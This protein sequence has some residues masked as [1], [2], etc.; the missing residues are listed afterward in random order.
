MSRDVLT[1]LLVYVT[2]VYMSMARPRGR[3]M[4]P[5]HEDLLA[6]V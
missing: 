1:P 2:I 4:D 6:P 5:R 3:Q